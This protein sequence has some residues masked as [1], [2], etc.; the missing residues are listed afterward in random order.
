VSERREGDVGSDRVR[1]QDIARVAGL[2]EA[3]VSR[4]LNDRPGVA[5]KTRQ[6]VLT[7]LDL[8][9]FE[10]PQRL[11]RHRS[12]LVGLIVPELIN[13]VFP[14]FVQVIETAL[15]QDGYTPILCT[16][17]PGGVPEGEYIDMLLERGVNGIIFV[18]ALHA[19]SSADHSQYKALVESG[20]PVV[21]VNGY[22]ADLPV[23]SIS[24][25]D[26]AATRTA[27]AHLYSL[28]HRRVGLATGPLRYMPSAFK[29]EAFLKT[30]KE[31]VQVD[32]SRLVEVSFFTVEG[33]S[34]AAVGLLDAKVTAIVCANDLM[35]LGVVRTARSR[36][37]KVPED[38]SV[39]GYDDSPLMAFTDPPLTTL[40]QPVRAMGEAAA[41]ALLDQLSGTPVPH[42]HLLFR[43]ELVVRGSTG[44]GPGLARGS[45]GIVGPDGKVTVA[46]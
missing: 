44:P 28:G 7:S 9:G 17:T 23:M 8:L 21:L 5:K 14:A 22:I 42:R 45:G 39:I 3:T 43:P 27:L 24:G 31:L 30:M 46:P 38:I 29:R 12:G 20:L 1:L 33:G 11:K 16:M 4:V 32:A 26:E 13:P 18:S 34:A 37:L 19:D 25:D 36:G 35:A 2:S 40:R 41:R 15:A 10:R 6:A